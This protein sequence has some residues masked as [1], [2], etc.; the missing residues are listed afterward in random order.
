M[1]K[2][3]SAASSA[4]PACS[5][6]SRSRPVLH[7]RSSQDAAAARGHARGRAALQRHRDRQLRASARTSTTGEIVV[8]LEL[9]DTGAGSS[10]STPPSTSV[11]QFAIVLDGVVESAPSIN[12]S[13]FGGQAQISGNFTVDEANNLVTV[14]KFGSLPLEI[15]EVGF[16]SISRHAGPRLPQPDHPRRRRS[17][18]RSSSPS[19]C[20]TTAC[21][22]SWPAS[23]SSS[24]ASSPTPSSELVARD[25]DAG[26]H[27]RLHPLGGHGRR[28]QHPH[29]RAHQGRA[30]QRQ[31]PARL[32]SR[33]ASTA[34]GPPSSTPTSR[35]S[36]PPLILY[37]FGTSVVKG[38]ALV[39][40][41]GVLLSM[42][43]AIV[44]SRMMLRWIVQQQLGP[45]GAPLRHRRLRAV[46]GRSQPPA[47]GLGLMFDIIGKR[48]YGYM[49]SAILVTI[50]LVF[51]LATLIPNGNVGPAV[52]HR[53]HRRHRLGGPLRG[54]HARSGRRCGPCS[55]SRVC[56][57]R[58]RHHRGRRPRVRAHPH[59]GALAAGTGAGRRFAPPLL[60]AE[61]P[62]AEPPKPTEA[63]ALESPAAQPRP[64]CAEPGELGSVRASPPSPSRRTP[65][66]P[67][68]RHRAGRRR[69]PCRSRRAI[70][71]DGP[72]PAAAVPTEGKFGELA[73]RAAGPSSAP[74][75]RSAR[76]TP[77]ARSSAPSSIQQTFLLILI[78]AGAI[79]VWV[80][81]P[82][83]RLP[84]G[85][86]RPRGAAPRRHHR[87]RLVRHPGH[88]HRAPDRRASS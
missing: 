55:R 86:H 6:S 46:G 88:V 36:S 83:P 15:R 22:A 44:L 37:Y 49:L 21:R 57:A 3:T 63:A 2:A 76:R 26:R 33:P 85:R 51:I 54:R 30:A 8:N 23:R 10:T 80:S 17:A 14:L 65:A 53:L 58:G 70:G 29:L 38:F 31:E 24:T 43:T 75:T 77:S 1:T 32:R 4:P 68:L 35:R 81:L 13:R 74:S 59:R 82:L 48:R 27:R 52:L 45:P 79:M 69:S 67:R 66:D 18:S 34:P 64:R 50:G 71:A 5:S 72:A 84:H 62:S 47:R 56:P 60:A 11:E 16:S 9:K 19:C 40:G 42:F 20:S 87:G 41:I 28:R 61:P 39:L 7:R 12:A 25:P 73:D 78:A